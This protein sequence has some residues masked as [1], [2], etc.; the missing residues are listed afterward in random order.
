M[1]NVDIGRTVC[2][3]DMA[4]FGFDVHGHLFGQPEFKGQSKWKTSL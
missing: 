3:T 1:G 2:R 4:G